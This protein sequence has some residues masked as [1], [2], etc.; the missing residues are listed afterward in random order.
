MVN[1][2]KKYKIV[3]LYDFSGI[4]CTDIVK[5]ILEVCVVSNPSSSYDKRELM[6]QLINLIEKGQTESIK[7]NFK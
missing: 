1:Q 4:P 2:H 6:E 7:M 5:S 3:M